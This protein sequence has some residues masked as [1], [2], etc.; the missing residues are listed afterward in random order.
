MHVN[1]NEKIFLILR[2]VPRAVRS[3][4]DGHT[5]A[6]KGTSGAR[7]RSSGRQKRSGANVTG[8]EP[9]GYHRA[10]QG[11]TRANRS[12]GSTPAQRAS[13]GSTHPPTFA[14]AKRKQ[15][16]WH[17]GTNDHDRKSKTDV[18]QADPGNRGG[19]M[20]EPADRDGFESGKIPAYSLADRIPISR[21]AER[22]WIYSC[23]SF[24]QFD[25]RREITL[26][27]VQQPSMRA[28]HHP[29]A[30]DTDVAVESAGRDGQ[31]FDPAR[32]EAGVFRSA[33]I[34]LAVP[35]QFEN[36]RFIA[37]ALLCIGQAVLELVRSGRRARYISEHTGKQACS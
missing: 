35:D 30:G 19:H 26:H 6:E 3:I 28:R 37:V 14:R 13:D 9:I 12:T 33:G 18:P 31:S 7:K 2:I 10:G 4:R 34:A 36:W 23:K 15:P 16:P 8:R 1:P 29:K 24:R 17:S 5:E 32:G 21:Y 11:H 25:S 22:S 20:H 27:R